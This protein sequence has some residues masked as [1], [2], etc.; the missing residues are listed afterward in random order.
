MTRNDWQDDGLAL[1]RRP[2]PSDPHCC[3]N[4]GEMALACSLRHRPGSTG[5]ARAHSAKQPLPLDSLSVL[6]FAAPE[7]IRFPH[8]NERCPKERM[9][10]TF[11]A[12]LSPGIGPSRKFTVS[13][14]H[15]FEEFL[16]QSYGRLLRNGPK[17]HDH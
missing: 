14:F 13:P 6:P 4:E 16:H 3:W 17:A 8:H 9:F 7:S 10:E 12:N 15:P 2:R 5:K 11:L 1:K